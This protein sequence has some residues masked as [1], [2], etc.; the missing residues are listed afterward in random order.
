MNLQLGFTLLLCLVQLTSFAQ[1]LMFKG[2]H[3][4][5]DYHQEYPLQ[6]ALE[7]GMVSIEAD[8]FMV[9]DQLLV[10]HEKKELKAQ[11]TLENLYLK[12]LFKEVQ[13]QGDHFQP[14]I[15]LVDFK[16]DGINTYR[17]LKKIS[18]P[19][20]TMLSVYKDGL[21]EQRAVTI[22]ISG[23][24]P[25]EIL[26]KEQHRYAF[27]D[28]NLNDLEQDVDAG[29]TPLL[30]ADWNDYFKWNGVDD[31]SDTEL[32]QL[33]QFVVQCHQKNIMLRFWGTPGEGEIAII[34][35]KLL[36]DAGVDLIG[37]DNPKEYNDFRKEYK[38]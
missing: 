32:K 24:R 28:G 26:K 14:I 37:T 13:Q 33:Q 30:S 1:D 18:Q 9:G 17:L 6:T 25:F 27:I 35:W 5:N 8:V 12:P 21:I 36:S 2:G 3:S 4:H 29:L 34:Y 16:A 23:D 20:E 15:L 22:I 19:Y 38:K 11:N 31:I 7:N 10:G